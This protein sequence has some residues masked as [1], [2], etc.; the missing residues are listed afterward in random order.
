MSLLPGCSSTCKPPPCSHA[1][2]SSI[3]Y[4]W[5]HHNQNSFSIGCGGDY[6][7]QH[8]LVVTSNPQNLEVYLHKSEVRDGCTP[9]PSNSN[10]QPKGWISR[11]RSSHSCALM[12][13]TCAPKS[14]KAATS[15]PSTT[16]GT[17]LA[18]PTNCA[19]GSGFRNRMGAIPFHPFLL[20]A[21][22]WVSFGLGSQRECF[23]LTVGCWRGFDCIPLGP[24]IPV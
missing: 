4:F 18:H 14:T 21:L 8:I 15:C 16:T 1:A 12:F 3:Y 6:Q 11:P 20:T 17:S 2:Q 10:N 23:E 7:Q 13:D 9:V 5:T 19:I 22:T 24:P